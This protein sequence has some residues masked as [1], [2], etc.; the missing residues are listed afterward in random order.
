MKPDTSP[1]PCGSRRDYAACCGRHH[2]GVPALDAE[3]LM[4]S[5]YSAFVLA[6]ADYLLATWHADTRPATLE[7]AD[8]SQTKWL[9]LEVKRH[10]RLSA[11]TA[12]VEFVARY[13]IGGGRAER[14]HEISDFVLVDGHWYYV[15]GE[16]A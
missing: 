2:D 6:R 1:C 13:R 4:R 3:A 16:F 7:L 8:A 10:Q 11:N 14:L 15:H 9:G 5:R 12:Q